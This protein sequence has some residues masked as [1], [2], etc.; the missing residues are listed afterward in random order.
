MVRT[1][2]E[3]RGR[4]NVRIDLHFGGRS[5]RGR[6][7]HCTR[8]D[9][10]GG[11]RGCARGRDESF[12]GWNRLSNANTASVVISAAKPSAAHEI[13]LKFVSVERKRDKNALLNRAGVKNAA[14]EHLRVPYASFDTRTGH[15]P[16]GSMHRPAGPLRQSESDFPPLAAI[17]CFKSAIMRVRRKAASLK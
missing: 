4:Q 10:A 14:S 17:Y 5:A 7:G 15:A 12:H 13:D 11:E 16:M 2:F 8:R 1:K 9:E 6:N 3:R